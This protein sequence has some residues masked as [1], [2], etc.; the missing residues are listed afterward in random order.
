MHTQV[1]ALVLIAAVLS[2]AG[3]GGETRKSEP[4]TTASRASISTQVASSATTTG[5]STQRTQSSKPLP[6]SQLIA[7]AN[8][9]CTRLGV[10]LAA[11]S[12]RVNSTQDLIR[13]APHR[14]AIERAA[15]AELRKLTPPSAMVHDWQVLIS[16]RATIAEDTAK[17][18]QYA[19]AG[20]NEGQRSVLTSSATVTQ[21]MA[22]AARHSGIKGCIELY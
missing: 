13:I 15:V 5:V 16:T 18:A 17:L 2:V 1:S 21:Q 11:R 12:E 4:T 8:S 6:E 10:K 3:C 22:A 7:R 14:V 19:A 20:D 9:I